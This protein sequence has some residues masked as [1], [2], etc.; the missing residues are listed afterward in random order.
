MRAIAGLPI[1]S[2]DLIQPG[3]SAVILATEVGDHPRYQGIE[4]ALQVPTSKLRLFGKPK[5]YKNRRMG[6]ALALGD[7]IET[8]RDRATACA[9]EVQILVE[10]SS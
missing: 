7:S 1:G 6:V 3:A 10:E 9:A 5:C 8:A 4:R 2:I